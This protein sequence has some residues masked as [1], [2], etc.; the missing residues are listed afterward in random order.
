MSGVSHAKGRHLG[1]DLPQLGSVFETTKGVSYD[2]KGRH[3][4]FKE[5]IINKLI[6]VA[7]SEN[8]GISRLGKLLHSSQSDR[9]TNS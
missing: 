9:M 5:P 3:P 8:K 7:K 4:K 2:E 6:L 1:S